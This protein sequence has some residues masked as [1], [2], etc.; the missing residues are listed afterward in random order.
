MIGSLGDLAGIEN[1]VVIPE[2][3]LF[4]DAE[5]RIFIVMVF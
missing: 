1:K 2:R 3:H 4:P 5:G